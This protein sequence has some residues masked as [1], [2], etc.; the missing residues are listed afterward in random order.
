MGCRC[1]ASEMRQGALGQVGTPLWPR[2][3]HGV[4]GVTCQSAWARAQHKAKPASSPGPSGKGWTAPRMEKQSQTRSD[5]A[6]L[7][8]NSFLARQAF[9]ER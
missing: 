7:D 9:L 3:A 4:R 1:G 2:L 6:E 5:H 8:L